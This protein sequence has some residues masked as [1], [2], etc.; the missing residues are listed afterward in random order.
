MTQNVI[1]QSVFDQN[2]SNDKTLFSFRFSSRHYKLIQ[3]PLI[4]TTLCD[5]INS[6]TFC[7]VSCIFCMLFLCKT[8]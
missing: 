5:C 6:I 3:K 1:E 4:D 2:M 8:I 7:V